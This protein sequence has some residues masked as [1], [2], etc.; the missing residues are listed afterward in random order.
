[1]NRLKREGVTPDYA[2]VHTRFRCGYRGAAIAKVNKAAEE[3]RVAALAAAIGERQLRREAIRRAMAIL[4]AA[5]VSQAMARESGH[6]I[7]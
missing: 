3:R 2:A 1:M 7:P 5:R 6:R 4:F